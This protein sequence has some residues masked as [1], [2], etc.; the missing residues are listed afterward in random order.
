MKKFIFA[1]LT[2]LAATCSFAVVN[3]NTA[4]QSELETLSG[5]GPAKARAIVEYRQQHGQFKSVEEIK[6]VKGIGDGIFAKLKAEAAVSS[7]P[8][9][10]VAPLPKVAPDAK[11]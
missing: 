3:I 10:K 2:A 5:I 4:S 7:A 9:Q 11:K 1:T 6:K 8:A